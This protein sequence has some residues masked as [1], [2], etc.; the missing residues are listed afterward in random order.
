MV[1]KDRKSTIKQL[2]DNKYTII[3]NHYEEYKEVPKPEH[4]NS[5]YKKFKD[6]YNEGDKDLHNELRVD[7]ELL[8]LNNMEK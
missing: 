4:V 8:L 1:F 7:C 6:M 5:Q 2:M 3:D